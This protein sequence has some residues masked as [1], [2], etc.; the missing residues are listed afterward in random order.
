MSRALVTLNTEADR[1]RVAHWVKMVP[2]GTRVEFIAA[3]RSLPQNK[4]MWAMLTDV[5]EQVRWHGL[6]L[7]PDDWKEIFSSSLS[8]ELRMVPNLD[9]DGFVQLGR[10]TSN[11]SVEEM[12]CMIELMFAFGANPDH[13]VTWKDPEIVSQMGQLEGPAPRQIEHQT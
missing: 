5:A 4:R 10:S 13:F 11:F 6:R 3:L 1:E 8:R 7:K 2:D 9:A 12:S